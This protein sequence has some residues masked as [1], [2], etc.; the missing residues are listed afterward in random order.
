MTVKDLLK[1]LRRTLNVRR[2]RV[3]EAAAPASSLSSQA[4]GTATT[5]GSDAAQRETDERG[6]RRVALE[7]FHDAAEVPISVRILSAVLLHRGGHFQDAWD[8]FN[9]LVKD[10]QRSG[11][12][13][14]KAGIL[15]D[16]YARMS[17]CL[18]HEGR[19][20]AALGPAV[21]AYAARAQAY[22][23]DGQLTSLDRLRT[24]AEFD[25]QIAPLAERA[26]LQPQLPALQA[27][28]N[29]HFGALP[30]LDIES[31]RLSVERFTRGRP[32]LLSPPSADGR[33]SP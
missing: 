7:H 12:D 22:A 31:L 10:P 18:E 2:S 3:A 1:V 26:Q 5:A 11:S 9:A 23:L 28:I 15:S 29:A 27:L 13:S 17:A 8:A 32:T 6:H 4:T 16:I 30:Q 24:A 33:V 19:Y 25:R 14:G 20:A 21:L